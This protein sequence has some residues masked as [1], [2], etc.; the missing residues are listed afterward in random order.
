MAGARHSK[1]DMDTIN[2]SRQKLREIDANLVALGAVDEAETSEETPAEDMP[3]DQPAEMGNAL[4][5]I[6][7]TDGELRVGNYIALFGGRDLTG[8]VYGKNADGTSGQYF[9][10]RTEFESDHTKAGTLP[11]DF[12]H[13][14]DPD[15]IGINSHD[16]LG[17]VDWKTAKKDK[18]GVFV[19]RVLN[20]QNK[21]VQWL[22]PLIEAGLVGNSTQ[23]VDGRVGISKSGEIVIWPLE[24]DSLTVTPM[25]PR[26]ISGNA[27]AALKSAAEHIPSLKSLVPAPEAASSVA[28]AVISTKSIEV[29]AMELTQ[30][31]IEALVNSAATKAV[32]QY[33][34]AEPPVIKAGSNVTVVKD[35]ADQPFASNGEFFKAVRIATLDSRSEDPRLRPLKATGL[36]EG[37][38]ADGGYLLQPAMSQSIMDRMYTTGQILSRVADDPVGPNSNGMVYNAID[39]TSRVAGSRWGGVQGYWLA[40]GGT[41]TA[42]KPKFRQMELKLK[43]LAALCYSTD[44][45]LA[46][47]TALGSWINRTVPEELRFLAEDAIYEGDGVGKPLGIMNSPALVT[48]TRDTGS[49]V[50]FADIVNMW[51]RR[52][53]GVSD[54]AWFVNSDVTPQLDQLVLAS[55]TEIPTRFIQYNAEG[56][57]TIKGKPVIEVEYA[58]TLNTTG[59]IMLAS[60]SQYQTITKG[61]IDSQSSIHVQF[62]TDETVFR[63]VMRIDGQPVWNSALT[64]FKGTNTLS[65]FVVLG[66]AT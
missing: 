33:Q 46:D 17:F 6:S 38:P 31:Q 7:K 39:E 49:K 24:R 5:A 19:E 18:R 34:K 27:L 59:D 35:A 36:S 41:K 30:E 14:K 55:S 3:E 65:P 44:E 8:V 60:L 22:E 63:F 11:V 48:V 32:E 53:A 2:D 61:G 21:Y 52:W 15:E 16:I 64:P 66:S 40:E 25:E 57:M 54:Y 26:M 10:E 50:L 42:S 43:K 23:A 4:K 29:K 13:G 9:S 51:A 47:A 56:V 45:L 58:S 20:R 28:A 12:E 37:V 62:L 1:A